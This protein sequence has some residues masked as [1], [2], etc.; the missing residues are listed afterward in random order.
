[1]KTLTMTHGF[2]VI[3]PVGSEI[4]STRGPHVTGVFLSVK[5]PQEERG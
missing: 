4:S 1:M 5:A 2:V 3:Y